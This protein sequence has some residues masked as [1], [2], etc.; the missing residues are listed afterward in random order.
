TAFN[1]NIPYTISG[2]PSW[3]TASSTSG[4]VSTAS[5]TTITFT[6]NAAGIS[7]A[8]ILGPA[9]IAFA[10]TFNHVGDATRTATVTVGEVTKASIVSALLP[11]SRSVQ[12]G[13]A[14]S[15]FATVIN[16]STVSAVNCSLAP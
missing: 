12:V 5:P 16:T 2:L 6:V 13:S 7:S 15:A 4:T 10:N 8:G 1:A 14:A 11:S 9:T 3:L